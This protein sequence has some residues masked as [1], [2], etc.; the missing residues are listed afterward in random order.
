MW[1]RFMNLSRR[2][3]ETPP[4]LFHLI[5]EKRKAAQDKGVDVIS[6]GIGDPDRPTPGFV[7]ELMNEEMRDPRNHVYPGYKG[8]PDF[9]AAVAEW[10]TDRFHVSLDPGT[11][12]MAVIGSKDAV[13]H[14]PFAFLDP[15][16]AGILTDPGYPVYSTAID[17]AGGQAIRVPLRAENGF[18]PDLDAIDPAAADRAKI[19]FVNYPNNP[20]SA[21][22]DAAFFERL[23]A[24][25]RKHDIVILSDNAYSEVY[26]EE[27]DRPIS[28]MEI[29]G[30]K[31]TSIEIH[32]FSKTFNMTGWRIGF[33]VGSKALIDAFL[34]LKSNFDSGVF[35]AIQRAACR[36][37][38]HPDAAAFHEQRTGLFKN[39]R[40]RIAKALQDMGFRFDVPRASYYFWV[41]IPDSYTSAMSFCADL[42]EQTGLVVTPGI[43][44]GPNGEGWFRIS[45]TTPDDRIDQAMARLREFMK[46]K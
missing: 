34:T 38:K 29:P 46:G 25:A 42:L 23:V 14:L 3:L 4:Y 6:L 10:F 30:A 19:M 35:M 44:Y 24:F 2:V 26:F 9:C 28:I 15:G 22:A 16:D 43:G 37:L 12:I 7:Q 5:D 41:R 1:R 45:M 13:S 31:E 39:R 27:E 8:E 33:I 17:F 11:E 32:S 36:A 18:L 21:V 20:T 40:D